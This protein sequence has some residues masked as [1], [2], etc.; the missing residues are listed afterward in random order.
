MPEKDHYQPFFFHFF[1]LHE[2]QAIHFEKNPEVDTVEAYKYQFAGDG[3]PEPVDFLE[4]SRESLD[5]YIKWYLELP[6][7]QG[8]RAA[9][10]MYE[11]SR[12]LLRAQ[13]LFEGEPISP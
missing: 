5:R 1:T 3:I 6:Q 12:F 7:P 10:E 13:L 4:L 2:G 9:A 8:E 11:V